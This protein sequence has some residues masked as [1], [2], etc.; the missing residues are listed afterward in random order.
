MKNT[1]KTILI[2]SF[3]II[4]ICSFFIPQANA[5]EWTYDG[6]DTERIPGFS[7]FPSEWYLYNWTGPYFAPENYTIMEVSKA[8]ISE[9]DYPLTM[10]PANGTTVFINMY[11]VNATSGEKSTI[12]EDGEFFWWNESVG[13]IAILPIIIP[14]GDNGK[15][16]EDILD[17]I[18]YYWNSWLGLGGEAYEYRAIYPNINSFALWNVS[19]NTAYWKQ[20]FT[21]TGIGKTLEYSGQYWGGPNMTL[22]SQPAQEPPEFSVTTEHDTLTVNSTE[23]KLKINVTDADNNN[24]GDVDTDYL[25][26]IQN[27][28]EWS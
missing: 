8:N 9:E 28:T 17:D 19:Y 18:S 14:V 5:Q 20:N 23:F 27:G 21:D 26:R 22:I 4:L 15:V 1:L 24:D 2:L 3:S 6:A 25:Y 7:I 16:T 11:M 13:Y 10:T 12:V